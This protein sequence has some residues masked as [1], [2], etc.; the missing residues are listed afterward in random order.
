MNDFGQLQLIWIR[1]LARESGRIIALMESGNLS[2]VDLVRY[3]KSISAIDEYC[4]FVIEAQDWD[5]IKNLPAIV[6]EV[7]EK[8]FIHF[9]ELIDHFDDDEVHLDFSNEDN[10]EIYLKFDD[11]FLNEVVFSIIDDEDTDFYL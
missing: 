8:L 3:K 6:D 4:R 10:G 2:V 1:R 5:D 9:Y 7:E 11:D